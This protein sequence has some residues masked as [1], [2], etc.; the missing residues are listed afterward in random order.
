MPSVSVT[1]FTL[2]VLRQMYFFEILFFPDGRP[3]DQG[4]K[5]D[6]KEPTSN[7]ID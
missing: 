1:F 5:E 2:A 7:I 3:F 4:R 6:L